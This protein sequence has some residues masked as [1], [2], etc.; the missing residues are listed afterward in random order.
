MKTIQL[1]KGKIALVDDD[2]FELVSRWKWRP[3]GRGGC[4][5]VTGKS[6]NLIHMSHV[7]L[8]VPSEILI[9]HAN[10]DPMDNRRENLRVC[11][12]TQNLHN[13]DL[14]ANSTSGY[15]GVTRDPQRKGKWV[16][17]ISVNGKRKWLG[18][19][20]FPEDAARAYDVAACELYGEF[21]RTNL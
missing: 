5:A 12:V 9:D 18:R 19:F 20:D 6:P 3:G 7:I 16:A 2:D 4:R 8:G 15:K 21:A 13:R 1:T 11:T 14:Q 10:R 17:R